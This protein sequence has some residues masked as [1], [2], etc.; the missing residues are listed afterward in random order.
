MGV[1]LL[2]AGFLPVWVG[3][4]A[5][6]WNLVWLIVLPFAT[7]RDIY[8][9]VLHHFVPLVVGVLLLMGVERAG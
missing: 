4:L 1:A 6:G 5:I 9:P 8:I 3:W 2:T 7:P